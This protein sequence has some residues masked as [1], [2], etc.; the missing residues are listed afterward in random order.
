[1]LCACACAR[2]S[3]ESKHIIGREQNHLDVA[4]AAQT[5]RQSGATSCGSSMLLLDDDPA[6][7]TTTSNISRI[8]HQHHL[9][10]TNAIEWLLD[11]SRI[12]IDERVDF[13]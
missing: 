4:S 5:R 7:S 6:G 2:K 8:P 10:A 12:R 9:V 3:P 13:S 11:S 1:M